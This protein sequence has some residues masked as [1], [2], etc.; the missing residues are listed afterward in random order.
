MSVGGS[1]VVHIYLLG[2]MALGF[3]DSCRYLS[4]QLGILITLTAAVFM[5][6]GIRPFCVIP[7]PATIAIV[8]FNLRVC[9]VERVAGIMLVTFSES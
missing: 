5:S 4:M 8:P 3:F 6:R 9:S 7:H 1:A 2:T